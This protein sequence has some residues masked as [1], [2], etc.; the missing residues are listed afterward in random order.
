MKK[1]LPAY[2]LKQLEDEKAA[3][4]RRTK[5]DIYNVTED[6][7][8]PESRYWK[9]EEAINEPLYPNM[10]QRYKR[11][12]LLMMSL[13]E[14]WINYKTIKLPDLKKLVMKTN[15]KEFSDDN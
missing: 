13:D 3:R 2:V 4:A 14:Y 12:P 10:S 1:S 9:L 15:G 7:L 6:M 11:R 8:P 5:L